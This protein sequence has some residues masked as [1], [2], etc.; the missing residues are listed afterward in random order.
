MATTLEGVARRYVAGKT[1]DW[2]GFYGTNPQHRKVRLP[3]YPFQR[4][5]YWVT[6]LATAPARTLGSSDRLKTLHLGRATEPYLGDHRLYGEV[7]VPGAR[8]VAL[9]LIAAR[10]QV[11][12]GPLVLE[13]CAFSRVLTLGNEDRR[14]ELSFENH[15]PERTSFR[16]AHREGPELREHARGGIARIT[17]VT[18]PEP[19]APQALQAGRP[20][21]SSD[22]LYARYAELSLD[23]GPA[24]RGVRRLWT[25][26]G[27]IFA[28][29]EAPAGLDLAGHEIHPA[30]L[31]AC[32]QVGM[33]AARSFDEL[34]IPWEIERVVLF[35]R[36]GGHFLPGGEP[37]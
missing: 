26:P 10:T 20:A 35:A 37:R 34:F 17:Q 18:P 6:D 9:A 28:E 14:I 3:T 25:G 31:D 19:I 36:P 32:F 22:A 16:I 11:G 13:G 24:F 21:R 23:L 1:V 33:A 2:A 8:F 15:S 29:I 5:R 30:L 4:Q 12:V 27:E 7:V